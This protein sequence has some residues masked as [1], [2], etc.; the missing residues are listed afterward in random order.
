M[1]II[2]KYNIQKLYFKKITF[3]LFSILIIAC[4]KEI[5]ENKNNLELEKSE[6][7]ILKSFEIKK[8]KT[9]PFLHTLNDT[10]FVNIKDYS[11]DFILDMKYA[12]TDNFLHQKVYD[13]SDCYL[14]K[15]TALAL[16]KA[17]REFIKKGYRIKIFD[18]YRPLDI[19]K[20]MWEILPR[21]NYVANPKK[22]SKHNRGAAVDLTLVDSLGNELDMGTKFDFF[23][24]E[25][26]HDY[27]NHTE[28]VLQNRKLL[29]ETLLKYN[30][31]FIYSEWWHYEFRPDR[32][33]KNANFKWECD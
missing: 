14:L 2:S 10:S 30:F 16:I 15:N 4:K 29:K 6:D 1:K 13:C 33:S 5:K 18:C 26:H 25:A 24:K 19:Q 23:G 9:I 3:I 20:K 12:T 31:K 32:H 11:S 22:G 21:T 28:E 7:T 8:E 17:N 27:I